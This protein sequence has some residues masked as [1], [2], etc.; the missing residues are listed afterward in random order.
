MYARYITLAGNLQKVSNFPDEPSTACSSRGVSET[1]R[2]SVSKSSPSFQQWITEDAPW[3]WL[4]N[5]YNYT[6]QQLTLAASCRTPN[7]SLLTA[8]HQ[9]RAP[10]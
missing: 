5:G 6:A 9:D 2:P 1:T 4:Y 7:D 8:A 3:V 10:S